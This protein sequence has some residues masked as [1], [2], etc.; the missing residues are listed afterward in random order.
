MALDAGNELR[1]GD[2]DLEISP[3]QV[4]RNYEGEI[5]VSDCLRPLIRKGILLC[6]FLGT[7]SGLLGWGGL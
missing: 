6:L 4:A 7:G 1:L 5:K 3:L 2:V